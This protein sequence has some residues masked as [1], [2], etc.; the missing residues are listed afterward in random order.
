MRRQHFQELSKLLIE[1]ATSVPQNDLYRDAKMSGFLRPLV[2]IMAQPST[3]LDTLWLAPR[4]FL[5]VKKHMDVNGVWCR[6]YEAL[7]LRKT[8]LALLD[9]LGFLEPHVL[10]SDPETFKWL[11]R[12]LQIL[13]TRHT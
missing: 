11:V 6:S 13:P 9:L 5:L 8:R 3:P 2:G 7:E 4:V 10:R 1:L 12:T